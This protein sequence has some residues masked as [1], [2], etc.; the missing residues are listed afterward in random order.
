MDGSSTTAGLES[1]DAGRASDAEQRLR[2][3]LRIFQA[4]ALTACALSEHKLQREA[5]DASAR[6]FQ[7]IQEEIERK[8]A[9]ERQRSSQEVHGEDPQDAQMNGDPY[10]AGKGEL[11]GV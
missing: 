10:L 5:E 1:A 11:Q 3:A 6:L 9:E 7:R 2:D 8:E 4:T